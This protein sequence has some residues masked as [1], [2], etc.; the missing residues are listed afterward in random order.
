MSFNSDIKEEMAE[1]KNS[2]KKIQ[3]ESLAY[4]MLQDQRKQNKR[5]FIIWI[6]TFIAFI[7]LLSYTI[8][9][10]NDFTV[11]ETSESESYDIEQNSGDGGSN[12]FI[13]GNNNE[14]NNG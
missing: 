11:I 7:G 13:N 8:Y 10:L 12:N 14:V 2:I 5:I 9:L 4:E 3:S 1:M 6:I